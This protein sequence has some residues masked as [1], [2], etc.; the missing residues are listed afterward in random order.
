MRR[1]LLR[2]ALFLLCFYL[3]VISNAERNLEHAI[4]IGG[5]GGKDFSLS[6]E[7]TYFIKADI[8]ILIIFDPLC[9]MIIFLAQ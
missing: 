1:S 5:Y 3:F 8:A 2:Q 7:M 4:C 9:T 6:F